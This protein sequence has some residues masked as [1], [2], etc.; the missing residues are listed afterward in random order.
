MT[1]LCL[2]LLAPTMTLDDAVA[3]A[4][5]LDVRDRSANVQVELAE[6]SQSRAFWQ[7][8]GPRAAGTV[9]G[10]FQQEIAFQG[11]VVQPAEQLTFGGQLTVPIYAHEVWGRRDQ[12]KYTVEQNQ[13][14]RTRTREQTA[15]DTIAAYYEVL[16][17]DRRVDLARS[18][19]E[20]AQAQVD[21]ANA[22]VKAGAALRTALLQAQID[23]DR[24]QRQV[25]D[26]QGQQY[27]AREQLSRLTGAPMDVGVVEPG[28]QQPGAGGPVD[29]LTAA[30]SA[31]PDLRAA[32]RGI[33][34][35]QADVDATRARL[36][37]T[38]AG[39]IS[40]THYEPQS[41]FVLGDVWRGVIT[42]TIPLLQGGTEYLDIRDRESNLSL[43][44]INRDSVRLQI[45]NDVARAWT[46]WETARRNAELS[47][48]Q[49]AFAKENHQLVVSQFKGGTATS[50]DV[51]VAQ[52]SLAEA[53][54]NFVIA[55]YDREIAAAGV[56]FQ[57]GNLLIGAD[58]AAATAR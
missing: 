48:H 50:T 13:A 17:A 7:I 2:L 22:R 54:I 35:A 26:T 25:A 14:T 58:R 6:R 38:L 56:R 10:T 52:S 37:P 47:E 51:T 1:I 55:R 31:R 28:P 27:V 8:F 21:L 41:V 53:E 33:S 19:V 23:L 5:K 46:Q 15:M 11:F 36:Y 57:T 24:Y 9:A 43:A 12:A 44:E 49:L 29:A 45:R 42:L 16:K 40:Y 18:Q 39:N 20:R 30:F 32:E 3:A 4:V 34:A